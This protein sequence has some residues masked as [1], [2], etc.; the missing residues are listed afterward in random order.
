MLPRA[1]LSLNADG[2]ITDI[3]T[4]DSLDAQPGVEFYSGI[5]IPGMVNAHCHLELSAL[6]GAIPPGGG[7]AGFARAMRGVKR[8]TDDRQRAIAAQDALLWQQ[9]VAAVA[10][11]SNGDS[12][13]DCKRSSRVDYLT[14]LELFG[15]NTLSSQHLVQ[16]AH[17]AAAAGL[18]YGLTPHS[19]YSLQRGPFAEAVAMTPGQ[20]LSVHFMESED[21]QQMF[22]REG[23]MWAWYGEQG[24]DPDF[25]GYG[26]PAGRIVAQVP[27]DRS[28]L[29]IHNTFITEEALDRLTAHFGGR[30]TFVLCPRSNRYLTGALPPVELLRRKGV[31]IALGTDSLASNTSLSMVEEMKMFPEVPLGEL[32]R[33]ATASG[34]E[35]LGL[36]ATLGTLEVGKAPGVAL[37]TGIDWQTMTLLP[38]ASTRRIV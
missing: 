7:F 19:T 15:M 31:R 10:D 16:V 22:R 30:V 36:S 29:L 28:I 24:H 23:E 3:S 27:G 38:D 32:L 9:G 13:F 18:R 17:Q 12:S 11:I 6:C 14:L 8:D 37:L 4:A 5:L 34:A 2:I 26:S 35:A 25:L 33:W 21:E 20:L 1:I